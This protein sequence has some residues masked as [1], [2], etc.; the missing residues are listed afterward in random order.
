MPGTRAASSS[1]DSICRQFFVDYYCKIYKGGPDRAHQAFAQSLQSVDHL[2]IA[3]SP[4]TADLVLELSCKENGEV[5]SLPGGLVTPQYH[6]SVEVLVRDPK[7][8]ALHNS[9][10]ENR[11]WSSGQPSRSAVRQSPPQHCH[12]AQNRQRYIRNIIP[13]LS[14]AHPAFDSSAKPAPVTAV[15]DSWKFL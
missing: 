6:P 5:T 15:E 8:N 10:R 12:A 11:S 4:V 2:Q 3:N 9:H 7:S 1:E 14:V 13:T